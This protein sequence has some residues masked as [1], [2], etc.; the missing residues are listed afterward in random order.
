MR[1]VSG[2]FRH[3]FQLASMLLTLIADAAHYLGLC[4]RPSP[5]LAAENLFLRKQ[6]ALYEERQVQPRRATNATRILLVWLSY[7]FNWRPVL[8]IVKPATFTCWHRQGFRLVWRW[9]S[10]RGRPALPQDVRALIRRM[11]LEN[12]TWGQERIADELLLKLGLRVSPRT[13]RKYMPRHCVGSL[14]TCCQSQRWATFL[15]NQAKGIVACDFC[16][17]VT[18]T[19]RLLYV[20]VMIEHE[21]RRLIHVNVTAHPTALHHEY[22]FEAWAA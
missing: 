1:K 5:A 3:L 21:S 18:A 7:C 13:V 4:L 8:R 2:R 9:Q 12:P 10:K 17:G 15:R 11:A 14:G 22:G 16:V 19:F 20:F 6:L